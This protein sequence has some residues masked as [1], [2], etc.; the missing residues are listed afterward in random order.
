MKQLLFDLLKIFLDLLFV[1][2]KLIIGMY[3]K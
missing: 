1:I 2:I 3:L